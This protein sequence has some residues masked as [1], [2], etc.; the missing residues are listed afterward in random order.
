MGIYACQLTACWLDWTRAGVIRPR[1]GDRLR[2]AGLLAAGY[3]PLHAN[4]LLVGRVTPGHGD[5]PDLG[6]RRRV[7]S[8]RLSGCGV[9][10]W[11]PWPLR[12]LEG[13][14]AKN[15]TGLVRERGPERLER[16]RRGCPRSSSWSARAA[17]T[18]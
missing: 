17:R 10:F 16:R 6:G 3:P 1:S 8:P 5:T 13:S 2:L 14:P 7:E 12:Y 18:R 15:V 11:G 9:P 4:R